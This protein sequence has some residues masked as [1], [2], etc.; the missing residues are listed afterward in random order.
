[1]MALQ[2]LEM[3]RVLNADGG[4]QEGLPFCPPFFLLSPPRL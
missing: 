2:A 1:M 3:V 4:S